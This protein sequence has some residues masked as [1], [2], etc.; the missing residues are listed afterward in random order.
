[1]SVE[2]FEILNVE[3]PDH[4]QLVKRKIDQDF[5]DEILN[6]IKFFT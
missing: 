4:F 2:E 5:D 1:M 6:I 3:N